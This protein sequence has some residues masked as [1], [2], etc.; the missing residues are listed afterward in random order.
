MKTG[1]NC[2]VLV[3]LIVYFCLTRFILKERE[4]F[5]YLR[6]VIFIM[7]ICDYGENYYYF[8]RGL[9][10]YMWLAGIYSWMS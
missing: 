4:W 1:L 9:F 3:V 2:L 6:F 10:V 5:L 7:Y 8:G